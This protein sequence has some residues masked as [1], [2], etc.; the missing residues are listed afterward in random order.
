MRRMGRKGLE[1]GDDGEGKVEKGE[2]V[3]GLDLVG[4]AGG[5]GWYKYLW[6]LGEKQEDVW[7]WLRRDPGVGDEK[8]TFL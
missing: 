2:E 1:L 6:F 5:V 7:F 8:A 4:L 3:G